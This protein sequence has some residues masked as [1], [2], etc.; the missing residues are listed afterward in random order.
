MSNGQAEIERLEAA[1]SAFEEIITTE[2]DSVEVPNVGPTPSLKKRVEEGLDER[3]PGPSVY[4]QKSPSQLDEYGYPDKSLYKNGDGFITYYPEYAVF[5]KDGGVWEYVT[6]HLRN[7]LTFNG[8]SQYAKA[9]RVDEID[10]D[11]PN[12]E[13]E[14][15]WYGSSPLGNY[16]ILGMDNTRQ[17]V[18]CFYLRDSAKVC[19]IFL[20][21][22]NNTFG[23]IS[24]VDGINSIKLLGGVL[25]LSNSSGSESKSVNIGVTRTYSD[26][27]I[28]AREVEDGLYERCYQGQLRD[29]KI[30]T[31]GDR[32]TGMLTR[33]YRM[34]QGWRGDNNKV[35]PNDATDLGAELLV[36]GKFD[37]DLSGWD[38]PSRAWS[39]VNGAA[40]LDS[41]G[42]VQS[43][44][45]ASIFTQG[46]TYVVTANY[47]SDPTNSQLAIF[48]GTP[49]YADGSPVVVSGGVV[50]T[51]DLNI[52][53]YVGV[54]YALLDN[55]S[56]KQADGYGR[57]VGF[58]QASWTQ[59]TV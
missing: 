53:R 21:G 38:N 42:S 17:D 12:L 54:N 57:Y 15:E 29:I 50:S 13:F 35:L 22:A 2:G 16:G 56:V 55:I 4:M 14:I 11:D 45:Q 28:G 18:P 31:G 5:R 52:K 10:L 25:T 23:K 9:P 36:N 19:S 26:L 43:L 39:W 20:G 30:W 58:T 40:R 32:N 1:T 27:T 7:V 24:L 47:T 44:R 6:P 37:T 34:D 3:V 46:D 49:L 48:S 59:E 8:V 41:D 33:Y 51:Q